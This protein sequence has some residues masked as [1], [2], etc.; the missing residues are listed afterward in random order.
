MK[1][2]II[3]PAVNGQEILEESL[4]LIL[5]NSVTNPE[6]ILIDNG[7]QN[8][9][10]YENEKQNIKIIRNEKNIGNYPTFKQGLELSSG[11][12]IA[13]LHSD[14]FI[15]ER[16]WDQR[17][18]DSFRDY[19][20]LGLLGFVGS[21]EIDG[22]GGR[23]SG[24]R[25]NM[26]GQLH[27]GFQG[28]KASDHGIVTFSYNK[29]AVVDGCS[30]IFRRE[31]L[32]RIGFR[33][34]FPLHHFYDR[35]MSCQILEAGYEVAI[36][37]IA[38]DHISGVTSNTSSE[39]QEITN[40]WFKENYNV[41]ELSEFLN[42]PGIKEFMIKRYGKEDIPHSWDEANYWLA[43]KMFLEE[44]RDKKHLIPIKI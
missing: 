11:D 44:Y 32:E 22:L 18:L 41:S 20:K 14:L 39:Y 1:L 26:Q 12:I 13:Y 17:V 8:I 36:L 4:Q 2:S 42:I 16:G 25:S 30:M 3:I 29:G 38:F 40:Q 7:S 28:S 31:S 19:P 15:E 43:E 5:D 9:L 23:G 6:I 35:L 34:N 21:N 10:E 24:T 27:G 37:G 33:E